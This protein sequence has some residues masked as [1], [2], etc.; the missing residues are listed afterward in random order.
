MLFSRLVV[1][2][3]MVDIMIICFAVFSETLPDAR[4][5]LFL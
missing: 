4:G 3:I 2:P 1:R 5:L